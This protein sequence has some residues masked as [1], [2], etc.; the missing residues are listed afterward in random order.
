MSQDM[1]ANAPMILLHILLGSLL[2]IRGSLTV[3]ELMGRVHNIVLIKC[4]F[5]SGKP[6]WGVGILGGRVHGSGEG[7][8]ELVYEQPGNEVDGSCH[9][10]RVPSK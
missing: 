5:G 1:L 4:I 6:K 2:L 9:K 3:R 8:G 10:R 7:T